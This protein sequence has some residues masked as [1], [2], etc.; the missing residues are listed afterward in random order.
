MNG[1]DVNRVGSV[2]K[3]AQCIQIS[4]VEGKCGLPKQAG[5]VKMTVK[6]NSLK[7]QNSISRLVCY[8]L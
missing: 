4:K 5:P 7:R 6:C 1:E 8:I 3:I 2:Q